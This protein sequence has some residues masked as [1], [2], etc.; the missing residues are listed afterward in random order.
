MLLPLALAC[1]RER[2]LAH[3][4]NAKYPERLA[5]YEGYVAEKVRRIEAAKARAGG[6]RW[7]ATMGATNKVSGVVVELQGLLTGSGG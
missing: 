7:G 5:A 4:S 3:P 6:E 2:A 1:A